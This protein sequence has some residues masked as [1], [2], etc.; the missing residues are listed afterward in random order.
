MCIEILVK[1]RNQ[2]FPCTTVQ[3]LADALRKEPD[4]VSPDPPQ[5]CLCN[6]YL[7]KLGARRATDEEGWPFPEYVI[8][9]KAW[10]ARFPG[11]R[12]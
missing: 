3:E 5:N 11:R 4:E 1:V 7:D 10:R 12:A 8:G 2:L 9:L 6:A